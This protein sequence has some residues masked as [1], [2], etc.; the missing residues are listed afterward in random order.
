[1]VEDY[2][3]GGLT[4]YHLSEEVAESQRDRYQDSEHVYLSMYL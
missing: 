4:T 3:L 1:M 2:E